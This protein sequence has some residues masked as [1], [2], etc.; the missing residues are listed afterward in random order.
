[1][2][3]SS[4]VAARKMRLF[5]TAVGS[6]QQCSPVGEWTG[7]VV[8]LFGRN[9]ETIMR[10]IVTLIFSMFVSCQ[11][12]ADECRNSARYDCTDPDG[13]RPRDK[14][15]LQNQIECLRTGQHLGEAKLAEC[16]ALAVRRAPEGQ[17]TACTQEA[18]Q[19]FEINKKACRSSKA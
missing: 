8:G 1:M 17:I 4:S 5:N 15:T 12:L 18:M 3:G 13:Q 19:V 6:L 2:L 9:R 10:A 14:R 7:R 16:V 11:G